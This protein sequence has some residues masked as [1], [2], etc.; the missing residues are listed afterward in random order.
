MPVL[1]GLTMLAAAPA[2]QTADP[3]ET[4]HFFIVFRGVRIGSE[5]VTVSRTA[6]T[7]TITSRGQIG[8]PL[9]LATDRFEMVYTNDWQPR[10]LS[11]QASLRSQPLVVSTTFGLTTAV[12]DVIQGERK[13]SVQHDVTPRTM[14]VPPSY[15]GAY[16]IMAARL[17]GLQPGA[18]F[19]VYVAPEGEFTATL[20]RVTPRRIVNPGGAIDLN[21]YDITLARPGL[22][23]SVTVWVDG[24]GRL[25]RVV[26]GNQGYAAIREDIGS[27]MSREEK[28]H[29]PGDAGVFIPASGFSLGATITTPADAAG[30]R[31][32]VILVGGQG[33]QD[34]DETQYGVPIFGQLAG[35]LAEAGYFVVR[36]DRRGVGQSGGRVEHAGIEEY[37]D[38]V[39]D[40]VTW[41]R[42]RKD[43]DTDRIVLVSHGDGSAFALAAAASERKIGGVALLA[44]PGQNGQAM[45]LLEQEALLTRLG[46]SQA[47]RQARMALQQK[48]IDAAITGKGWDDIPPDLQQ[49]NSEWFRTWL[50][51]EPAAPIR[52]MNQPLLVLHGS[53]DR[54]TPPTNGARL[55]ELGLARKGVPQTA[56]R[57]VVVPGVNHLLVPATT[58]EPDEYETLPTQTISPEVVSALVD[59]LN[60]IKK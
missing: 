38:D 25:A 26:F 17:P 20:N 56:T 28:I 15:F 53:L 39:K 48:I 1:A 35:R 50:L 19:P 52:K 37:A 4:S 59:W 24:R 45:V 29:N 34:R 33:R 21:E 46:V 58:G 22:P 54:E 13:G 51:F 43:I 30:R 2:A 3:G 42:K 49:A 8:Q 57:R 44:A 41:L 11:I 32:A 60:Q 18:R 12:S 14:V 27:V 16:E 36:F 47:D 23:T 55:E 6:G 10:T 9:E 40:I 5:V 7:F 31:P